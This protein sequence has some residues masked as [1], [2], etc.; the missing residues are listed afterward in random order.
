MISAASF[1]AASSAWFAAFFLAFFVLSVSLACF[2]SSFLHRLQVFHSVVQ[3]KRVVCGRRTFARCHLLWRGLG[4]P[5]TQVRW[6][7]WSARALQMSIISPREGD[8]E[9]GQSQ[10]IA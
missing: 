2:F 10:V 5:E 8:Q 1:W 7:R 4:H 9:G 3:A 6:M